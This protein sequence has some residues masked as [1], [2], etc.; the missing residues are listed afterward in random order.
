[1]GTLIGPSGLPAT[2]AETTAPG[3][4]AHDS[5]GCVQVGLKMIISALRKPVGRGNS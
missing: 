4:D 1:M 2:P 5:L 3:L